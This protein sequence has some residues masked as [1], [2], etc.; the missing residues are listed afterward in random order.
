MVTIG[1]NYHVIPGKESQFESAFRGVANALEKA[2]GH[3]FSKL[4][5]DCGE[6]EKYLIISQWKDEAAY[7][8]FI[9]SGAFRNVTNWGA[10]EILMGRPSHQVY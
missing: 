3:D 4:Y 10:S 8:A 6:S 2:E 5:R 1:M 7:R 9:A